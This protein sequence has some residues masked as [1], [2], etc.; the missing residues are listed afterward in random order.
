[1]NIS[2]KTAF[3]SACALIACAAF[4]QQPAPQAQ[5]KPAPA[6]TAV[7]NT[8]EDRSYLADYSGK[9]ASVVLFDEKTRRE[10]TVAY[11]S[12]TDSDIVFIGGG[13]EIHVSK[14]KPSSLKVVVKPDNN[15]IRVRSAL[16]RENWDEAIVYLRP[17]VYPLLPLMSISEDTFKGY[18]YLEMYLNALV[19]ANRMKEA[20]SILDSLKLGEVSPT[21]VST[22]LNTAEVF[23]KSGDKKSALEIVDRAPF[24][25]GYVQCIPDMLS[26]LAELRK[27]GALQ[28]CGVYYTK[29]MN[30]E[31]PQ[32]N[33][34][35]L[36]MVYCD[37]SVGKKMSAEIYLDR[38]KLDAKSPEF[39]LYKMAKGMLA[40]K[41]DKP[42]LKEVLDSY[43]EGIVFGSLT[44]SWMPELLYNA[45]MT[46]K[47]LGKQYAANEI[48][49]QMKAL[50]PND[51]LTAKGQKEIVKIDRKPKRSDED[52]DDEDDE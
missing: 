16:E 35:T 23:A 42:D 5:E 11:K 34:A 2:R 19:K 8:N 6:P 12:E 52:G 31:S 47:K 32:K 1:M 24:T 13:G 46:Y 44:S 27:G 25:G 14:K 28:E 18:V 50:Y 41:A 40:S 10:N 7:V 22:A 9:A 15:W 39:S 17:F 30:V 29:L 49:A 3:V 38:M 43:A 36:W 48:F 21:L 45:G 20:F 33:E 26:A 4:A 37:L 51:S